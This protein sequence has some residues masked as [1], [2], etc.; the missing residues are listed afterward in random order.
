[1]GILGRGRILAVHP[2]SS[3]PFL[4]GVVISEYPGSGTVSRIQ[5]VSQVCPYTGRNPSFLLKVPFWGYSA[6]TRDST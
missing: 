2:S 6:E 1:M 4:T 3:Q 5:E